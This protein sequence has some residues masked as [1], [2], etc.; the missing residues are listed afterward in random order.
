MKVDE[1]EAGP[2]MLAY[3]SDAQYIVRLVPT[4]IASHTLSICHRELITE[5]P[6]RTPTLRGRTLHKVTRCASASGRHCPIIFWKCGGRLVVG[7]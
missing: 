3:S 5:A 4:S 7:S 2:L 6:K 1:A